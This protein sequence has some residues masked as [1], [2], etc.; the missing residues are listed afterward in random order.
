[1]GWCRLQDLAASDAVRVHSKQGAIVRPLAALLQYITQQPLRGC[2]I[3]RMGRLSTG[4]VKWGA[5]RGTRRDRRDRDPVGRA[6]AGRRGRAPVDGIP[7][8][9]TAREAA[10]VRSFVGPFTEAWPKS[11]RQRLNFACLVAGYHRLRKLLVQSLNWMRCRCVTAA[12]DGRRLPNRRRSFAASR[13]RTAAGRPW[14]RA[15]PE[16]RSPGSAGT[17]GRCRHS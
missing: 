13:V 12:P 5:R 17:T 1:M 6:R 3:A 9:H 14:I 15:R 10:H 16:G 8:F 11:I 2:S 7:L 4:L